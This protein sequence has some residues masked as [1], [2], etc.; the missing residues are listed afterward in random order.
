MA[1]SFSPACSHRPPP[2]SHHRRWSAAACCCGLPGCDNRVLAEQ[3]KRGG[4]P[5]GDVVY[6]RLSLLIYNK[7][8]SGADQ[9]EGLLP[10]ASPTMVRG[11]RREKNKNMDGWHNN[12]DRKWARTLKP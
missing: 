4:A 12:I 8:C 3:A 5:L 7:G 1:S 10:A 11:V 2:P 6:H 9:D